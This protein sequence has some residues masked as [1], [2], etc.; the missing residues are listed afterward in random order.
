MTAD[1]RTGEAE[2]NIKLRDLNDEPPV[3]EQ[4]EYVFVV[5]ERSAIGTHLG[6][7]EA[8]DRDV[9]DIVT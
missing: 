5:V 8:N 9:F 6:Y 3:F 4:P 2:V 7:V 1:P